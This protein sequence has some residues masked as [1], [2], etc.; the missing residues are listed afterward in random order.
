MWRRP[1]SD[2]TPV[3][4]SHKDLDMWVMDTPSG[5]RMMKISGLVENA[6]P[7][8]LFREVFHQV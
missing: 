5:G 6:E 8:A 7:E 2:W 1:E 3:S 4:V